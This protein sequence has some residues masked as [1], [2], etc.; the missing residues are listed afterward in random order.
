[1]PNTSVENAADRRTRQWAATYAS[2]AEYAAPEIYLGRRLH[3]FENWGP[4]PSAGSHVLQVGCGDGYFAGLLLEHGYRVTA[5]DKA[6]ELIEKTRQ[7]NQPFLDA[8]MLR[9]EIVD[10]NKPWQ[11][12]QE[13]DHTIAVMRSFFRY[14]DAPEFGLR[15]IAAAT[16]HKLLIDVDPRQYSVRLARRQIADAGFTGIRARAFLTPQKRQLARPIQKLLWSWE[17]IPLL[18][19]PLLCRKF[20]VWMAAVREANSP[21]GHGR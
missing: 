17:C 6:P 15:Q 18:Y 5:I 20:H 14:C 4:R 1:M 8:G 11:L 19:R 12:A 16:R 2:T 3:V 10:I 21:E 9:T 13:F 7:R